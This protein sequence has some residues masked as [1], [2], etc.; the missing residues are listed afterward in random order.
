MPFESFARD[1]NQDVFT[2]IALALGSLLLSR[3]PVIGLL[4]YPFRLFVT[5]VHELCHG[6]AALLSGGSFLRFAI[7]PDGSGVATTRGGVPWLIISAG[8]VGSALV[9]GGLLVLAAQPEHAPRVL[10]GL[11]LAL[12]VLCLL[13]ARN[14]FGFVAGFALAVGLVYAARS[15]EP[16]VAQ[17]LLIFLAV[18]ATLVSFDNLFLQMRQ[19]LLGRRLRTDAH[20]MAERT[21]IPALFWVLLWIGF[22]VYM[23]WLALNYAYR[24]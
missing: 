23:L 13:F 3:V 17:L 20:L 9:G 19:S 14:L 18:Q 24:S 7:T 10:L 2:I 4:F 1:W 22:S 12:G 16:Q 11:G 15:L 8:Y 5:F 6:F 21:G